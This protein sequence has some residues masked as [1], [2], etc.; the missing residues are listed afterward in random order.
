MLLIG[1]LNIQQIGPFVGDHLADG[2]FQITLVTD[3]RGPATVALSN[4][5]EV[6]ITIFGV[7]E[8]IRIARTTASS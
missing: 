3:G 5:D 8:S 6:W 7:A 4:F 1:D 2:G